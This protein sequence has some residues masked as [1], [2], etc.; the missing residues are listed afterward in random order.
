MEISIANLIDQLSICNQRI[1][2]AEDI[3]RKPDATDKEIADACRITNLANT[4][5]NNL[6]EAIDNY[7][8]IYTGQGITKLYG[9]K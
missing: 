9:K 6:I 2:A 4:Q 1:W 8:G 5:R 7:F 3:K